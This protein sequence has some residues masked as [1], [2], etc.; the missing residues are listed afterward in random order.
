MADVYSKAKRSEIMSRVRTRRTAPEDAVAAMLR[1]LRAR[2]RRNVKSLPGNPDLL[3]PAARTAIFVHGCF[4]HGH[5]NCNRA[6]LPKTN[7]AFWR[8]KIAGNRMRDARNARKLRK[9]GW[10]VLTVWQCRLRKPDQV[11]NRLKRVLMVSGF[12][13]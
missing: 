2:F 10:H 5:P 12:A 13:R 3:V 6:K 7:R 9:E 8:S 4:W 1:R 11:L